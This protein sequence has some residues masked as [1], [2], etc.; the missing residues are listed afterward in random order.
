MPRGYA[1]KWLDIDL[2]DRIV[3]TLIRR[4]NPP[5]ST[6]ED[7][8]SQR[9]YSGTDLDNDGRQVDPLGPENIFTA[10][11]GPLTA[12]HP[13]RKNLCSGKS[14]LSNGISAQ[15]PAPNSLQS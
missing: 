1:G 6:L 4:Y 15:L 12:I 7:A 14:P 5:S 13:G 3:K 11:T 8:A 9:R 2:S 10:L